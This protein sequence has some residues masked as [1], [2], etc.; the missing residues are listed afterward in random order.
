LGKRRYN[1]IA[2]TDSI[3]TGIIILGCGL[4]TLTGLHKVGGWHALVSHV[5]QAAH[6]AKPYND[7]NYPFLGIILS[8]F[9]GGIFYWGVDQVS[10]QRVLW[11]RNIDQAR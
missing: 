4:M 6:I 3:Q 2:Y 7:P 5:P 8:A 10:V 1:A 11:T 9:Y